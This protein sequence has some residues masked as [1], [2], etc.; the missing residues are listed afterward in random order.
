MKILLR[1]SGANHR[2]EDS[3]FSFEHA[4][5]SR[6]R[7]PREVGSRVKFPVETFALSFIPATL[8]AGISR[9]RTIVFIWD[10]RSDCF[11]IELVECCIGHFTCERASG[12][13]RAR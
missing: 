2:G 8:A 10:Y 7:N 5:N 6:K 4:A 9:E 3:K 1:R 13:L 12:H 11:F